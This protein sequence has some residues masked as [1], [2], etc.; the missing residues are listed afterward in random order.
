MQLAAEIAKATGD[1]TLGEH[2]ADAGQDQGDGDFPAGWIEELAKDLVANRGRALV[3]AGAQQP[4]AVHLL[5][6]GD[7]L[8]ARRVRQYAGGHRRRSRSRRRKIEELAKDIADKKVTTLL[9]SAA[10]RSITRRRTSSGRSCRQSVPNVIRVGTHEDETSQLATWHVP[11][12]H[13]L[14]YWGDGRSADG[15]YVAVQPMILPL[16]RRVVG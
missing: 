7:Q 3:L 9:S 15:T 1:A 8:G 12:A 14:E 16:L 11:R 10:T 13:Y 5:G 6:D 2:C 4:V